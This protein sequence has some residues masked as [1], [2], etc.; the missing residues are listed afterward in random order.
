MNEYL[1]L[2][3]KACLVALIEKRGR[4]VDDVL[5]AA[6][7]KDIGQG[8]I[9]TLTVAE[10]RIIIDCVVNTRD[11]NSE[12]LMALIDTLSEAAGVALQ[13]ADLPSFA[14]HAQTVDCIWRDYEDELAS[15]RRDAA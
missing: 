11:A 12:R 14:D 1:T 13:K 10:A 2:S 7:R 5:A 3:Q 15:C 4:T 8:D 9:E 6:A